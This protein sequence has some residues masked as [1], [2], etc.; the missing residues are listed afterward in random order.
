MSRRKTISVSSFLAIV[1]AI[2][3]AACSKTADESPSPAPETTPVPAAEAQAATRKENVYTFRIGTLS[4]TALLDGS[5]EL[6]N[7]NKVFG[8]GRTPEEVAAVLSAAGQPTDK[9]KLTIQ[10][11]LVK[12]SD[13]VLLFDTGAGTLFGPGTGKLMASFADAGLDPQSVT[14]IFISH[15]HGDHVGGLVNTEGKLAFPNAKIHLSK[16]EWDFMSGQDQYKAMVTA[17]GPR[18]DAFAPGAELVPGIVTAIEI[19]GHTPGHSGYLINSGQDSLLYVGDSMH[20]Y[21]VSVHKPEW[22]IAFDGD[23]PTASAS[24]ASLIA[25]SASSAQ[26]IY[27]VHFPFPGLGRM[28]ERG[29]GFVWVA[30]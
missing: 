10:P 28:A 27:A 11:L 25:E 2:A 15:S 18:I 1:A 20:H 21:I 13:R 22:T 3:L 29:G 30:E 16:T 6:P 12:T 19:R 24:R 4:A 9:L 7:D 17:I 8:V 26:R 14:D 23:S 5:M